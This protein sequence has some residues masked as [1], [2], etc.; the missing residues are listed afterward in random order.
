MNT[1]RI[2]L[3]GPMGRVCAHSIEQDMNALTLMVK[4]PPVADALVADHNHTAPRLISALT[5]SVAPAAVHGWH[6]HYGWS[7]GHHHHYGWS[8]H[9]H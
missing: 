8:H 1:V 5:L 3:R 6:H 2:A 9:H 4:I 7:H